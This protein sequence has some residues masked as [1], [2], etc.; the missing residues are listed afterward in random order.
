MH[1]FL[2]YFLLRDTAH[3]LFLATARLQL[4]VLGKHWSRDLLVREAY[5]PEMSTSFNRL[6]NPCF[7]RGDESKL[8][9]TRHFCYLSPIV[10]NAGHGIISVKI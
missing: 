5:H 3:T 7:I 1:G 10:S 6:K 9:A 4:T 2:F 8:G